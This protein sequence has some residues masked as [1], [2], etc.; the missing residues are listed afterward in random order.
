MRIL[1]IDPSSNRIETS[2]T[3]IVLL[4]NA[5]LVSYWVVPFGARNFSRWFREV[6]RDLEYD[7]VIVE[8]YQV[9]DNDYSRDNSVA[10]TVEAV[11]ACFPNV[12]LVRNAGY[13]SDIPDQL[14]RKLGLWTFDKS[15]H[16]DVRAAAR[17]ALF[18]AQ[19]KDIEEVIQDIGN[20]IAQMAS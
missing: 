12:E 5:G 10:E 15:H 4:D 6:G 7:V 16:Q 1:A 14:L 9:R 2:T 20:R 17:L 3:G 11:Q 8:E 19:R 13:V 18:W